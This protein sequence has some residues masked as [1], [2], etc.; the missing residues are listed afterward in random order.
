MALRLRMSIWP[1]F[2]ESAHTNSKRTRR[3]TGSE[4]NFECARVCVQL[5]TNLL[6]PVSLSPSRDLL[7][8]LRGAL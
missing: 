7:I 5:L 6:C 3:F 2:S 1:L 4:L 8:K